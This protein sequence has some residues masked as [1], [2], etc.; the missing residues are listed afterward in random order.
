MRKPTLQKKHLIAAIA[1]AKHLPRNTICRHT[2]DPTPEK[3]HS[4]ALNAISSLPS[5]AI[6]I[7]TSEI[8]IACKGAETGY[9]WGF[10]F[11][12]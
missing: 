7:N 2:R 3:N 10:P 8:Y 5:R 9:P 6:C 11:G 12:Q 1:V 4:N